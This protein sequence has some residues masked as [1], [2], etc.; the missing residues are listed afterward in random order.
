MV[1][2]A[3]ATVVIALGGAAMGALAGVIGSYFVLRSATLNLAQQERE[4]WRTRLIE[5]IQAETDAWLH[6]GMLLVPVTLGGAVFDA[7]VKVKFQASLTTY[8]QTLSR[9][10][11]LF[12][13]DSEPGRIAARLENK[14]AEI[15]TLVL[16]TPT[17]SYEAR[18]AVHLEVRGAD[19][20]HEAL[21]REAHRA[22]RPPSWKAP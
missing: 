11:L 10:I 20:G 4:A 3:W 13:K 5:A 17:A 19:R 14:V 21:M 7:G 16:N 22:I 12:G 9:V 18:D 1:L 15:M 2:P 8:G 6:T